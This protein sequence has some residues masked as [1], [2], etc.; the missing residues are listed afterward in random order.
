MPNLINVAKDA[1]GKVDKKGQWAIVSYSFSLV[2]TSLI[3]GLAIILVSRIVN[4][5]NENLTDNSP[6]G[7]FALGAICLGL[8]VLRSVIA[9]A[10]TWI[11]VFAMARQETL[12]GSKN[13]ESYLNMRWDIRTTEKIS[14][15]YAFVDRGPYALTQQLLMV[16]A[17]LFSEV[18]SCL[19]VL[20]VI[21]KLDWLIALSSSVFFGLVALMQHRYISQLSSSAGEEI[22]KH[23]NRTYDL[24]SDSFHLGK[25]LQVMPSISLTGA[26]EDSRSKLARARAKS[27]FLESLPRYLMESIFVLGVIVVS[28]TVLI[29]RGSEFV[30]GSLVIFLIA[31][32]RL[33]PSL[34]RIQG[35]ILGLM[36][37]LPLAQ[38]GQRATQTRPSAPIMTNRVLHNDKL[39]L[40]L[41]HIS[42]A[43]PGS[44][45]D[46]IKDI[47]FEFFRGLQYAIVGPSGSGK[48]TF[49]DML[50]G[51]LEPSSGDIIWYL[52]AADKF[53]YVPQDNA[54]SS[55]TLHNNVALE[56]NSE[57]VDNEKS[58]SALNFA[59]L[60]SLNNH[61]NV[62]TEGFLN[63]LSGGERQRLGIARAFYREPTIIFMD[64]PTSSLDGFTEHKIVETIDAIRGSHTVFV[65]SHRL[66]TIQ[67]ADLVMYLDN[68]ELIAC[69]SFE[70]L[71]LTVPDFERQIQLGLI[72]DE[73]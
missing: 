11:G 33:L 19:V 12:F 47:S 57:S 10:I 7:I 58:Y 36:G 55:T 51:L 42:Y 48:T 64:E 2:L 54:I 67:N 21:I 62:H 41:N 70:R 4:L 45:T 26:L 52:N 13:F 60:D 1:W 53:A 68:G 25:V 73:S 5:A 9:A 3:D 39:L 17:T 38:E 35:L 23:Q 49:L 69:D 28:T 37:R 63:S 15:V 56:W 14:G 30:I 66:S 29:V 65:V 71:R 40:S 43:Y 34:N 44:Q 27:V 6:N 16:F 50:V 20:I 31:G 8:F 22:V 18:C 46:T 32:F 72:S 61:G 59:E 24:L